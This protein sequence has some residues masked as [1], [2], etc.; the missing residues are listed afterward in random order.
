MSS[1]YAPMSAK[2]GQAWMIRD[3]SVGSATAAMPASSR[4]AA[5]V[6]HRDQ[7]EDSVPIALSR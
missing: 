5:M 3:H 2:L 6:T 1:S 7:R 4:T